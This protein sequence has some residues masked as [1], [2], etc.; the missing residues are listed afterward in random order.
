MDRSS[1]TL[2]GPLLP[3]PGDRRRRVRHKL[4]TPVYASFNEPQAEMVVDLSELLDLNEDGFCVQTPTAS[5][6]IQGADRQDTDRLEVNRP[7]TLSLDLSET[8]N[9]VHG[10]GVVVWRDDAGRAGVRFSFIPEPSMTALKEWLFVNLLVGS[11]N[12]AARTEQLAR[13]GQ[14]ESA[15]KRVPAPVLVPSP[16]AG[17]DRAQ[18]LSDLDDVRRQV[19][20]IEARAIETGED[21][22][23]AILQLITERAMSLTGATGSALALMSDERMVCRAR[24]GDPAP[25]LGSEV[26]VE[27]GLSGESVRSG[28][29]VLCE[30]TENDA[31]VD[32]EL[33]RAIGI[34]S[35]LAAP[36]VSDF[37]VIGLLE[38][39]SSHARTFSNAEGAILERLVELIPRPRVKTD[40]TNGAGPAELPAEA[41]KNSGETNKQQATES[42]GPECV[43]ETVSERPAAE[44]PT[45]ELK[46]NEPRSAEFST[47]EPKPAEPSTTESPEVASAPDNTVD[48]TMPLDHLR[49]ALW[50]RGP[51]LEQQV[52]A[53]R[54][55]E[56]QEGPE[57]KSSPSAHS[58]AAHFALIA[59][60]L[61][62]AALAAGYLL[63]PV[64]ERHRMGAAQSTLNSP[65]VPFQGMDTRRVLAATPEDLHKRAEQGDAE[66]QFMLGTLYRNGDGVRQND[67]QAIEWFQRAA[68]QGY[69]RA[70]SAL[71]SSY[72]AGRGVRQDYSRAYF[73]YQLAVAE[74]DQN[75]KSLLE[76]LS[77][78]MTREQVAN[79]RQQ[80][81]AWL[82]AHNQPSTS[83]SK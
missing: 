64:I 36:I 22:A 10:N 72:W 52:A 19:R 44:A 66:A 78:Q 39:L 56:S 35:F 43:T 55:R 41:K 83:A 48:K 21:Y 7:V 79:V 18:L 23:A 12:H 60:S 33:C 4:H 71:G 51:E 61:A 29:V 6:E 32:S 54:A 30:D 76:G 14:E 57:R 34:G 2:P 42:S 17:P 75:S 26:N 53:D 69:V 3:S 80:A 24:A 58:H 9:Y 67:A 27:E 37:R 73:W 46:T 1:A 50:E 49:A 45:A 11:N 63:A 15:D 38:V 16:M 25:P 77:T 62:A 31:R 40:V 28:K 68:D 8:K 47:S 20:E 81:E 70:L 82:H 59:S 5:A 65:A 13:Q 74:G